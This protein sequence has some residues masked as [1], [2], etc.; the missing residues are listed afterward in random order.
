MRRIK[1]WIALA[2]I[3][4]QL[5]ICIL[6]SHALS[7]TTFNILAPVHRSMDV[8]RE[9]LLNGLDPLCPCPPS[10][11]NDD[12]DINHRESEREDWWRP[13]AEGVADYIAKRF[14]SSDVVLLQECKLCIVCIHVYLV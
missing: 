7:I 11:D 2:M 10:Y 12:D 5:L 4:L 14:S 8:E 6:S 13:R 9:L 3:L 1:G